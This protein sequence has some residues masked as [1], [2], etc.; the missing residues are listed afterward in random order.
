M[1]SSEQKRTP[2]VCAIQP[3]QTAF[4]K[5]IMDGLSNWM[6]QVLA[7]VNQWALKKLGIKMQEI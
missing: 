6:K 4:D 3:A 7:D 2:S 5:A 1:S